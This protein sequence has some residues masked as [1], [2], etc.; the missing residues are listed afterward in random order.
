MTVNGVLYCIS[1]A[2]V[3]R[4][5]SRIAAATTTKRPTNNTN[6]STFWCSKINCGSTTCLFEQAKN[7]DQYH[8]KYTH[9]HTHFA[10][11]FQSIAYRFS[12]SKSL[13]LE[14]FFHIF[15]SV[16]DSFMLSPRL[17]Q[18]MRGERRTAGGEERAAFGIFVH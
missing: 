11:V 10:T 13:L 14:L 12:P 6:L 4:Q 16:G 9:T 1:R 15:R 8:L 3:A 2:S 18:S 17:H 5:H 7:D